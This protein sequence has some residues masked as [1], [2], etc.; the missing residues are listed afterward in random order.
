IRVWSAGCASGEEA[1]T[2]AVV[3]LEALGEEEFKRR[4]KIYATDVDEEALV[5][6]R[7]AV[8]APKAV[9]EMPAELIERYFTEKGREFAFRQ[10]LRRSVIFGRNELVQDAPIPR[11]DLLVCRNVL[12]YF[13]VE[14]QT[15]I[16]SQL[17][18][19][20]RDRGFLFLGKSEMLVRH[21]DYFS[22]VDVK[23]R[24]FKRI[25]RR[26]HCERIGE[27]VCQT[28]MDDAHTPPPR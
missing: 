27:V 25:P 11:I 1:Y 10:D 5:E 18:F 2:I 16:L 13:T 26:N 23:W 22:P 24:V 6:A 7:A 14:A 17:N 12:M 21:S 4:V 9:E 8:Y 28:A 20:L 15:R 3:L 19:A